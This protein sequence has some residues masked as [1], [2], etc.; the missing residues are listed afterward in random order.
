MAFVYSVWYCDLCSV[1]VW[2]TSW[3]RGTLLWLRCGIDQWRI[4][5]LHGHYSTCYKRHLQSA[6]SLLTALGQLL[7]SLCCPAHSAWLFGASVWETVLQWWYYSWAVL[8]SVDEI[9]G[10]T[11]HRCVCVWGGEV[12]VNGWLSQ[13]IHWGECVLECVCVGGDV[14]ESVG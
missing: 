11:V 12:S 9:V 4:L 14:E 7:L 3:P 8:C 13:Q 5:C 6:L 1:A 2:L 10:V